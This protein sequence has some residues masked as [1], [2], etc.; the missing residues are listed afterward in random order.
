MADFSFQELDLSRKRGLGQSQSIRCFAQGA[1]F[2]DKNERPE[3]F[4]IHA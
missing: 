1:C 4:K 2:G 3:L